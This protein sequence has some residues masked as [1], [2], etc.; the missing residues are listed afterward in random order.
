M[1]GNALAEY[2]AQRVSPSY[3]SVLKDLV[4]AKLA[5]NNINMHVP[6]EM[7]DKEDF[8][9]LDVLV[10]GGVSRIKAMEIFGDVPMVKNG[11]CLSILYKDCLQVDL[12]KTNEDYFE[13]HREYLSY[14]DRGMIIGRLARSLGYSFG[15]DGLWFKDGNRKYLLTRNWRDALLFLGYDG[16]DLGFISEDHLHDW[17]LSSNLMW[18]G[19]IRADSE[20]RKKR[21][22]D[23]LRPSFKRFMKK[24][25]EQKDLFP[26]RHPLIKFGV[27]EYADAWFKND[28]M[29]RV[30]DDRKFEERRAAA[31]EKFS[32]KHMLE[33]FGDLPPK[34]FGLFMSYWNG[35][36]KNEATKISYIEKSTIEGLEHDAREVFA[37]F[38]DN[39][40]M[41]EVE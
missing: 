21:K 5:G 24:F 40:N 29:R 31:R 19:V 32:G 13:F 6:T 2:G 14:G 22:R 12:I 16:Y 1:G 35:E 18:Q 20:N 11:D 3:Y 33:M 30:E 34:Q 26:A 41:K 17:L 10:V 15:H 38:W 9:D 37:E 25:E 28:L 4:C 7:P 8:G 39:Y 27:I 36:F 23:R